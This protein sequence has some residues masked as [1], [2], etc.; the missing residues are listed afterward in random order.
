M[1]ERRGFFSLLWAF[2]SSIWWFFIGFLR[3]VNAIMGALLSLVA[4]MVI[5]VI[6]ASL[7]ADEDA[8]SNIPDNSVLIVNP[9]G[10]IAE[11]EVELVP[12]RLLSPGLGLVSLYELVDIINEATEDSRIN[13][14]VLRLEELQGLNMT[15]TEVLGQALIRF[16]EANKTVI[17][18]GL[19]YSQAQY[20]LA[21]YADKIF[22]HPMGSVTFGG[23]GL[24]RSYLKAALDKLG[25]KANLFRAGEHKSAGEVFLRNKMSEAE[26]TSNA[27]IVNTLWSNYKDILRENRQL[28]PETLDELAI[29]PNDALSKALGSFVEVAIEAGLVDQLMNTNE[30][31]EFIKRGL[32]TTNGQIETSAINYKTYIR[33]NIETALPSIFATQNQ[34]LQVGLIVAEGVIVASAQGRGSEPVIAADT[35]IQAIRRA[36]QND[37]IKALVVR[38]NTPGG[39]PFASEVIRQ[40]LELVQEIGKP[41]VISM[42]AV[43]ASGGYWIASTADEIWASKATITG[44]IGV[45][46]LLPTF[47][48]T[49][50]KLGINIDGA[51]IGMLA[52]IVP[53]REF[54]ENFNRW[55]Q[56]GIDEIYQRFAVLVASGRNFNKAEIAQISN[57]K[58]WTGAAAAELR[59]VDKIGSLED[60]LESAAEKANLSGVDWKVKRLKAS[61]PWW[62]KLVDELLP[63]NLSHT[64]LSIL[65]GIAQD[66]L[67]VEELMAQPGKPYVLCLQCE[68]SN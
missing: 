28:A 40:E 50:N 17:T 20:L 58:V 61:A 64:G 55:V 36:R 49:A 46:A 67:V 33:S 2:I 34:A 38:L 54:P 31:N 24:H 18:Y 41:V 57:G 56:S 37:N 8:I 5:I 9:S 26:K 27:A 4:M 60:A 66:L 11:S 51:S 6:L 3:S 25:I 21:S 52:G 44:S 19:Q 39:E 68:I 53:T 32:T 7:S 16:Q 45:F 48:E 13:G 63:S 29:R 10:T 42:G 30:L 1:A 47:A 43:A 23:F 22:M 59:L 15:H 62:D 14:L 12:F 35:M 65:S